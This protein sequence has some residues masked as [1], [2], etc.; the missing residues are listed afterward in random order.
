[1][2][3]RK[4]SFARW[5]ARS[6]MNDIKKL[7]SKNTM[8]IEDLK[9]STEHFFLEVA[10][11]KTENTALKSKCQILEKKMLELEKKSMRWM[12]TAEG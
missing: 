4:I 3:C 9:K 12:P 8:D 7:V 5:L 11:V 1:M 2:K 10:D 6:N